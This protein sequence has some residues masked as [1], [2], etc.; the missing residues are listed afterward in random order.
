MNN[1]DQPVAIA[2]VVMTLN[3]VANIRKCLESLSAIDKVFVLDSYSTDGTVEIAESFKNVSVIQ[4]K[5]TGY[6]STFN[7]GVALALNF[8]WVLRIDA[9]EELVGDV[10]SLISGLAND[11]AGVIVQRKIIFQGQPLRFGPHAHLKMLRLFKPKQGYCE[12]TSADEHIIVDGPSIYSTAVTIWDRDEKPFSDWITK[13]IR[14]AKKEATN[15]LQGAA[16]SVPKHLDAYNR[17]KRFAKVSVYYRF[18]PYVRAFLYFAYR[19][20]FRLECL[21]GRNGIS[22]CVLQGLWYRL[23]IDFYLLYPNLIDEESSPGKVK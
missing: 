14:W 20:F 3:E 18:P 23:L 17:R 21:G 19:F 6:A 7:E 1:K 16:Q 13:H 2:A 12:P 22:W 9:D 4:L 5:W 15:V 10:R 11:V 8:D